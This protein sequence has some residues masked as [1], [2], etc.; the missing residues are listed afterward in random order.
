MRLGINMFCFCL[1]LQLQQAIDWPQGGRQECEELQRRAAAR[2]RQR[3]LPA[4]R[5]EQGRHPV[6]HQ[7]RQHPAHVDRC[8]AAR[9]LRPTHRSQT[10]RNERPNQNA[11]ILRRSR[12]WVPHTFHVLS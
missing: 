12:F 8:P 11:N 2:R 1:G 4:V 5:I 9:I 10:F 3:H 6:G 7:L